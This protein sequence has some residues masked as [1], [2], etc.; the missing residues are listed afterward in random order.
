MTHVLQRFAEDSEFVPEVFS[1]AR[2]AAPLSVSASS[3]CVVSFVFV[4]LYFLFLKF[5]EP[6]QANA[7]AGDVCAWVRGVYWFW[8]TAAGR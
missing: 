1:K 3:S 4:E 8:I 5:T 6:S 7:H 2:V